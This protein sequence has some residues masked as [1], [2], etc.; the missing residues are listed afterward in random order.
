[1]HEKSGAGI[2]FPA[3][4]MLSR[5]ALSGFAVASCASRQGSEQGFQYAHYDFDYFLGSFVHGLVCFIVVFMAFPRPVPPGAERSVE[6]LRSGVGVYVAA[7]VGAVGVVLIHELDV[8]IGYGKGRTHCGAPHKA[9]HHARNVALLEI[10]F[11]IQDGSRKIV[12]VQLLVF[13]QR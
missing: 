11:K 4:P 1:M 5:C 8:L 6:I 10:L 12:V 9:H 3:P 13:Q 2:F 7:V